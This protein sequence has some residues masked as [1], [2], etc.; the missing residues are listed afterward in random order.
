MLEVPGYQVERELGRGGMA[1]VYLATQ[2]SL[3]RLVALKVLDRGVAG[4][5]DLARRFVNEAHTLA[6]LH[7]RNI[8]TVY[9]VVESAHADFIVMEF[10]GQGSLGG[11]LAV[12]LD[13]QRSL[14]ILAQLGSALDAAHASG[15]VHRDIKPENVLFRDADTPVLTD[16]GIARQTAPESHRVTQPGL[17]VGTPSYMSPEQISGD[18]IDGRADQYSLGAMF[19][20]LLTGKPPFQAESISDLLHAHLVRPVPALP[21]PL[22]PLQPA[23]DRMLAKSPDDR[24]PNLAAMLA[25]VSRLLLRAPELLRAPPGAPAVSATE[26]LHQLGFPTTGE[27]SDIISETRLMR[28]VS[29]AGAGSD[30]MVSERLS[31]APSARRSRLIAWGLATTILLALVALAVWQRP[32][33]T[34]AVE[35]AT[36]VVPTP[37]VVR[38]QAP[39]IAVLPFAD[40][41]Q[42]KDQEYM[43]DGL[44]EELLT[45]LTQVPGLRVIA[46]TSSFSFEDKSVD[47]ATIGKALAVEH[48]LQGSVR[49]VGDQLRITSQLVRAADNTQLWSQTF[50]R[51]VGDVFAVQE[52]IAAAVVSELKITLMSGPPKLQR[53]SPE[54]F[55]LFL[56][57]RQSGRLGTLASRRQAVTLYKRVLALD[58]A[59]VPAWVGLS[60]NYGNLANDGG[61][62][63]DQGFA[64]ARE[65]ADQALEIDPNNSRAHAQ[66][67]YV[68]FNFDNDLPLAARRIQTALSLKPDDLGSLLTAAGLALSLGR[69]EQA[70]ALNRYVVWRD[71]VNPTAHY[72]LGVALLFGGHNAEAI[73]SW[74]QVLALSPDF[75]GAWYSIGAAQLSLQQPAAALSS[76]RNE[77]SEILRAIGLP[78]AYHALGQTP[79]ADAAL[80]ELE[81]MYGDDAAFNVAYVHAL[82]GEPDKAFEWLERAVRNKD[83]GL[84]DIIYEPNLASLRTDPRWLPLLRKLGRA[85]E[86]LAAV[87]FEA[88][89]PP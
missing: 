9:D 55:S 60:T 26:R 72:N 77:K 87:T 88:R 40:L 51:T 68:A 53:T 14:A 67:A 80:A 57:A 37:A 34:P 27:H 38:Q 18:A 85:P 28:G 36:A 5:A 62:P 46:R 16:F 56:R 47:V 71:P 66:R 86:Q 75:A 74:R 24:Y 7:H 2:L 17:S 25:D 82:R 23:I 15:I 52:E 42:E 35:T 58:P 21:L 29:P 49:R 48:V 43:S 6:G 83:T 79:K 78:M 22:A 54:A 45:L 84:P 3:K 73:A 19:F 10:L 8:V 65:A 50:D 59:Y 4:Y 11:R 44:A 70:T 32:S 30:C 12:G 41:S 89:P 61:M 20:E 64:L 76:I 13:V 1:V 39:S 33:P 81:R 63:L 69:L 31:A